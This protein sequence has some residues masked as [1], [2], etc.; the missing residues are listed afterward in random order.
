[1][2][3]NNQLASVGQR[4]IAMLLDGLVIVIPF[5]ILNHAIPLLGGLAVLFFYAPILESSELRA[6]LGKYWMGIQVKD[7][8]GQR[9]T[10]RT[11]IIRNIVKAFSS[12]LFFIGHVVALFTE[13]RQAV[14][15]LLADTVV[16]S[17]HSEHD[18]M[19]AW[20]SALRELFRATKNSPQDKLA[21]L[22]R[23]QAL[24]ERGAISEEEFQ[25]EK[26]KLLSEY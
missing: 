10:L 14:H 18:A 15:D 24:R 1:M 23:L 7:T 11:A 20:S 8:E 17:G 3:D 5:A 25:A 13:K 26:K 22:E 12:M 4:F 6:T 16:V 21:R 19:V 9:I 2:N